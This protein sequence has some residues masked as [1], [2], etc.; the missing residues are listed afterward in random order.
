MN[1]TTFNNIMKIYIKCN[2]YDNKNGNNKNNNNNRN[3]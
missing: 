1:I 2:L 3:I